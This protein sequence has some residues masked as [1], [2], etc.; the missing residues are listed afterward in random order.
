M[1]KMKEKKTHSLYKLGS[2]IIF[3]ILQKPTHTHF[4]YKTM[5]PQRGKRNVYLKK[6][7]QALV[8]PFFLLNFVDQSKLP[9]N[10]SSGYKT[11]NGNRQSAPQSVHLLYKTKFTLLHRKKKKKKKNPKEKKKSSLCPA[12]HHVGASLTELKFIHTDNLGWHGG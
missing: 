2:Y 10:D 11:K 8:F 4:Q 7:F 9:A 6:G 1:Y 5:Q 3:F 12:L